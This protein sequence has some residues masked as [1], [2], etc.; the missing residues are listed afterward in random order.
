MSTHTVRSCPI[1]LT[2]WVAV[3]GEMWE[4]VGTALARVSRPGL[5]TVGAGPAA[6]R[7]RPQC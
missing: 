3:P 6:G 5:A 4:A 1:L 7:F 2:S